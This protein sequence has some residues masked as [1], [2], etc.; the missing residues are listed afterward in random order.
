MFSKQKP[1]LSNLEGTC[2]SDSQLPKRTTK[3][4]LEDDEE[5]IEN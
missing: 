3:F 4:N 1:P 5:N 2:Q